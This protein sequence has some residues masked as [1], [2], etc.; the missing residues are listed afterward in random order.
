[1][2]IEEIGVKMYSAYE[3][4]KAD[5]SPLFV[6]RMEIFKWWSKQLPTAT[7]PPASKHHVTL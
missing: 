2:V 5:R 1:M 7:Q 4:R 6:Q 3:T